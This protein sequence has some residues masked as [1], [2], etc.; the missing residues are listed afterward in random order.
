[1]KNTHT[2]Q[3]I[4][5]LMFEYVQRIRN[6]ETKTE[7]K[8]LLK[9][10]KNLERHYNDCNEKNLNGKKY[11]KKQVP[12]KTTK[13]ELFKLIDSV[14]TPEQEYYNMEAMGKEY[15]DVSGV[16]INKKQLVETKVLYHD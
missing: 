11:P 6:A 8:E 1:M 16:F 12:P 5:K 9:Q 7:K 4:E 13:E 2:V 14:E 3:D 15:L 10:L